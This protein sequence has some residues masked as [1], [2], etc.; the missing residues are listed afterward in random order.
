MKVGDLVRW[1]YY[2]KDDERGTAFGIGVVVRRDPSGWWWVADGS[3]TPAHVDGAVA[4][5]SEELEVISESR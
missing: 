4:W 2:D 5:P 1:K 3:D